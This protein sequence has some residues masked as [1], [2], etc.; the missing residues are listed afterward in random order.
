M[1]FTDVSRDAGVDF[2]HVNGAS[3]DKH[4]VETIGSGGLF[5]DYDNDGW[6]DIFLVDGGSLADPAVAKQARH[7]L[8]RN[9]GNGTFEDVTAESGIRIAS[10]AWA[11]A[12]ATTTTTAG[13]ISTSRTSARTS[14]YRNGGNGS[15]HRR[16]PRR[17]RRRPRVV[18]HE[19]RLRGSRPGRRPRPVRRQLRGRRRE[20]QP[21]LRQ[22]AAADARSTAI[23]ST[24]NRCRTSSTATTATASSRTSAHSPASARYRG[25]GLGVVIADFDNDGWP[26][27]FVANDSVPNFLFH[28]TGAWRFAETALRRRR[29]RGHRRQG[30][31]GHGHRCRRLR[32]RR[33]AGSGR[34]QSRFRDAQPVPRPGRRAVR[35]RHAGERDRASRRCPLSASASRSST[36]TTTCSSTSPSPTATSWTTPPQFRAGATLRAAQTAVSQ[37]HAA[38]A[39]PRSAA[40]PGRASRWKRSAAGSSS[41]DIDND[42]D[43]DLL[44]TNNGQTADLLRNDGGS[45][46]TRCSSARSAT[47]SNR[48][49]VGA[50]LRLTAGSR[51]QIRE[52]KAGSSYLGQN[53]ARQHFGLGDGRPGSIGSRCGGQAGGPSSSR[54]WRR[55]RSSRSGRA[56]ASLAGSRSL[57]ETARLFLPRRLLDGTCT[58]IWF[59]WHRRHVVS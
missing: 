21:F 38:A 7:R 32:R 58:R 39:S 59:P 35:I 45:G 36:S 27:V 53:D 23:R 10:T 3:P 54:T 46:A 52:V 55:T 34:H 41:G 14:L 8:Y 50:R 15:L 9:R 11:P 4:L 31:R 29:R 17:A 12:R 51:T 49:G 24:S 25:N 5:F 56:T 13:S 43:L 33:P 19:L 26:D 40:A 48:D 30:A 37:P 6:I 20:A 28:R 16:H 22:R 47:Q 2:R 18:E 57:V 44:V 1:R 42:G